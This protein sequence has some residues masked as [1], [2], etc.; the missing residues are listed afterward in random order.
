MSA[1]WLID[2][3]LLLLVL[4]LLLHLHVGLSL[5][6]SLVGLLSLLGS[7]I[8]GT[9]STSTVS[10]SGASSSTSGTSGSTWGSNTTDGSSGGATELSTESVDDTGLIC[11]IGISAEA[12]L[13]GDLLL[14]GNESGGLGI[15]RLDSTSG[16]DNLLLVGL[17]WG[18]GE[19]LLGDR[20]VLLDSG[21]S[22]ILLEELGALDPIINKQKN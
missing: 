1:A 15:L 22:E 21:L 8:S 20:L 17:C 3:G 19:S 6:N 4:L 13:V 14:V 12:D 2:L 9:T 16:V 5:L 7:G 11:L 10:R 18:N